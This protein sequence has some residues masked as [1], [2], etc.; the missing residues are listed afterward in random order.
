MRDHRGLHHYAGLHSRPA[1]VVQD[2]LFDGLDSV[3]VCPLTS[4]LV[5]APLLRLPIASTEVSGIETDSHIMI[6]KITTVR[7]T[8]VGSRVGEINPQQLVELERR[9]LVFLGIAR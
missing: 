5:D 1:V 2:E 7:R 6:D 8:N 4:T 9:L 3:T